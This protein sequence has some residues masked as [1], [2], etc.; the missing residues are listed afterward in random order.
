M[1]KPGSGHRV[2]NY[3]WYEA[4]LM[5]QDRRRGGHSCLQGIA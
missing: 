2:K 1:V 5:Y 4:I 3:D